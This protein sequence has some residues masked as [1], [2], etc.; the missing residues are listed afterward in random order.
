[1]NKF[2]Y[3]S[4]CGM[5]SSFVAFLQSNVD[6]R[7]LSFKC[8]HSEYS[9]FIIQGI[10]GRDPD[11]KTSYLL[12]GSSLY[13]KSDAIFYSIDLSKSKFIRYAI[14]PFIWTNQFIWMNNLFNFFY[15]QVSKRRKTCRVKF[16]SLE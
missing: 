9:K 4:K 6:S 16:S 12:L 11:M 2:F 7:N 5:C 1:M 8:L 15:D 3:D 13:E 10:T 14:K